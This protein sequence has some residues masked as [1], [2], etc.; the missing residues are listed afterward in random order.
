MLKQ[1]SQNQR[2]PA[3]QLASVLRQ[4]GYPAPK[5]N[6]MAA[7]LIRP[8]KIVEKASKKKACIPKSSSEN[9]AFVVGRNRE[10]NCWIQGN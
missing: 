7:Q 9:L 1:K 6:K 10:D 5:S 3:G 4:M 2:F 8:A